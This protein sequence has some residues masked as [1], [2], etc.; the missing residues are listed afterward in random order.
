MFVPFPHSILR[1]FLIFFLASTALH[2][3]IATD[4]LHYIDVAGMSRLE[5]STDIVGA[6]LFMFV[7][8]LV[9][10][11]VSCWASVARL[12]KCGLATGL[13]FISP[14]SLLD[15]MV[16]QHETPMSLQVSACAPPKLLTRSR[17]FGS[18]HVFVHLASR[19]KMLWD[20]NATSCILPFTLQSWSS[21]YVQTWMAMRFA[22]ILREKAIA[23]TEQILTAR[24]CH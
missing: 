4:L 24:V 21:W 7:L 19:S 6:I 3:S 13:G 18:C 22:G 11:L 20:F 16:L 14:Y 15:D 10:L 8:T 9:R 1:F 23:K 5:Y 12:A 17:Y 2:H